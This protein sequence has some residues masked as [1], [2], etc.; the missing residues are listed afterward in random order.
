LLAHKAENIELTERYSVLLPPTM[1]T[2]ELDCLDYFTIVGCKMWQLQLAKTARNCM[3]RKF[4]FTDMLLSSHIEVFGSSTPPLVKDANVAGYFLIVISSPCP[5][6]DNG[7]SVGNLSSSHQHLEGALPS[8]GS[9][10]PML[11]PRNSNTSSWFQSAESNN[12][13]S[14]SLSEF[15]VD[16]GI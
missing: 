16:L 14:I 13:D 11:W 6:A 5:G 2:V 15:T 8:R 7:T 4:S 1:T 3:R 9:T 12:S 10:F